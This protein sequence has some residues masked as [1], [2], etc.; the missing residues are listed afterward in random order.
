MTD[1]AFSKRDETLLTSLADYAA[2]AIENANL[3]EQA[4]HE[5]T[6]RTRAEQES[7]KRANQAEALARVAMRINQLDLAA[8]LEAVCE[9]A[10]RVVPSMPQAALML[11]DEQHDVLY[12][13]ASTGS[14]AEA[15][16]QTSLVPRAWY[17]EMMEAQGQVIIIPD[18]L[19][20]A[21]LPNAELLAGQKTRTIVSISMMHEND[22]IGSLNIASNGEIYLPGEEEMA[23]LQAL[24]NQATVAIAN[25]R[26]FKQISE[27]RSHLQALSQTLVKVQEAERRNL[28]VELHDEIGQVLTSLSLTLDLIGRTTGAEVPAEGAISEGLS[29]AQSLVNQLLKQV[30]DLSLDLRP[31]LLDDLGLLPALIS[32]FERY[33]AQTDIQVDFKHSGLESRF[34][35]E[36]ETAAFRIIQEALTNVARYAQVNDVAVRL[37]ANEEILGVQVQDQ[38]VGFDPEAID[39]TR[40]TS[41][42]SGM[43]E[44]AN[45]CGGQVEIESEPGGGT[46]LTA[47]FPL[48]SENDYLDPA[49]R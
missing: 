35:P 40:P 18:A 25:A 36:I 14:T 49:G 7:V 29:Q 23:M 22:L 2:V 32:L 12:V 30:R 16:Q 43:R 26:L 4:Q 9:E 20:I 1:R 5:I 37:W 31:A 15:V 21:D 47:E 11:C 46:C 42:L 38:G 45:L 27:S 39:L 6:E 19:K 34:A 13:A 17:E 10:V 8:I 24:A 3:Y 48:R 28:A 33:T 44:R 41:G